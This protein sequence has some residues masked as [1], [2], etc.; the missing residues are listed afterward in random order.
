[1]NNEKDLQILKT[2]LKPSFWRNLKSI[3]RQNKKSV[4][5]QFL[6]GSDRDSSQGSIPTLQEMEEKIENLQNQVNFLQDRI[7]LLETTLENSKYPLSATRMIEK[8]SSSS[9]QKEAQNRSYFITLKKISEDEQN[10]IIKLG[11]QLQAQRRIS[12]KKYYESTDPYSL[13]QSKGYSTK[14]EAIRKT[15]LYKQ[16][17]PSNN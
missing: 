14:Y 2:N 17:K 9:N 7:R 6:F 8:A 5:L 4:L 11:F 12:L 1:M 16:L 13:F 15:D 3:L 10:E